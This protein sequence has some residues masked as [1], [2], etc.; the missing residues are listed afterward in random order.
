M[1]NELDD[2]GIIKRLNGMD[3]QQTQQYIKLSCKKYINKHQK[4]ANKPLPMRNNSSYLATLVLTEG[5]TKIKE[6]QALEQQM[7]FRYGQVIGKAIFAMTLCRIDIETAIIRRSHSSTQPAKCHYQALKS[8]M[9]LLESIEKKGKKHGKWWETKQKVDH[10]QK[11][12]EQW[13]SLLRERVKGARSRGVN[14][15]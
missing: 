9:V 11:L 10:G 14:F 6:Q 12:P 15:V 4:H 8:L 7:G 5:P 2:L 13:T 3:I 1:Q